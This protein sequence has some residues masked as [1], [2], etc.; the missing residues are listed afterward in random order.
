MIDHSAV[1]FHLELK[2]FTLGCVTAL[3]ISVILI[4]YFANI[5]LP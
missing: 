4:Y 3:V 1:N 5:L 2:L